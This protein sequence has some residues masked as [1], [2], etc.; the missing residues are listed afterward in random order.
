MYNCA[1]M[2]FNGDGIPVNKKEAEK[3]Y[4]IA[5]DKGITEAM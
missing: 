2:L 3:L 1:L 4:K 5:A